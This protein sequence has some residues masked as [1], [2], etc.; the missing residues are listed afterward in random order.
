[1]ER[2]LVK[3][4]VYGFL[5]GLLVGVV[6]FPDTETTRYISGIREVTYE[7]LRAYIIKLIRF[8]S[9][10]SLFTM[11]GIWVKDY[12]VLTNKKTGLIEFIKGVLLSFMIGLVLI[13]AASLIVSYFK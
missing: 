9:L 7:P 10:L 6:L 5:I 12:F 13:L 8:S 1:M 4:G 2:K 3:G 11:A